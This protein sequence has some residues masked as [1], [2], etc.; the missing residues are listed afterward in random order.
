[1]DEED[2][3]TDIN[4]LMFDRSVRELIV[5]HFQFGCSKK[6]KLGYEVSTKMLKNFDF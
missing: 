3:V 4:A 6:S 1:M 5:S 2:E